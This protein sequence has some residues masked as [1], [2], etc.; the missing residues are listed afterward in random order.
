MQPY[1]FPYLGYFQLIHAVDRFSILDD[2][3]FIKGGWINRNRILREGEPQ[4]FTVPLLRASPN[5]LI[6]DTAIAPDH[7]KSKLLRMFHFAYQKAPYRTEVMK[8]V[9]AVIGGPADSIGSMA[10]ASLYAV[11]SYVGMESEFVPSTSVYENRSMKAQARV[12]DICRQEGAQVYVNLPGGRDLYDSRDF[13]AAGI[14][15]RFIESLPYAYDQLGH[16]FQP[17]LSIIDV[18]MFNGRDGTRKL[19]DSYRLATAEELQ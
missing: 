13:T 8:L 14:E 5:R 1:L 17:G 2:V 11:C 10:L 4:R 6:R 15:L 7:W 18:L 19:L 3:N 16:P 9:E 12:L